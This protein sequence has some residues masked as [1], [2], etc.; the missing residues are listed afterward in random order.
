VRPRDEATAAAA[1][2]VLLQSAGGEA[3]R[4]A[5]A[6]LEGLGIDPY[7]ALAEA[8]EAAKARCSGASGPLRKDAGPAGAVR[9]RA[10]MDAGGVLAL[11]M[12]RTEAAGLAV[13]L[14]DA[15]T[16]RGQRWT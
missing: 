10:P 9:V 12:S 16:G 15:M 5:T 4:C 2:E 13:V 8:R 14:Q 11:E 6:A 1:V 3:R 7:S